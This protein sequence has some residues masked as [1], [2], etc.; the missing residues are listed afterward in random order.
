MIWIGPEPPD[1]A[2]AR[3]ALLDRA[4]G[5][6]RLFRTAERL[7]EGRLPAPGLVFASLDSSDAG[8]SELVGTL[9]FWNVRIGERIDALL[10]GPVA[11]A[12]S[13]RDQGV[14]ARLIRRGLAAAVALGHGAVILVGDAPYYRRFGFDAAPA[15]GFDLPGPVD[16][17]RLLGLELAPGALAAADGL[18]HPA[19]EAASRQ[20]RA[21]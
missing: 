9:R 2:P 17:L 10:L 16:R 1:A 4:F 12:E 11:V 13:R 8:G 5:A 7:R 20:R 18:V 6:G 15:R 3:E 14:G 21:A 19:G